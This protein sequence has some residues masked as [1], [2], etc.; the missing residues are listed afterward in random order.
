MREYRYTALTTSGHTVSG[1]RH[2][3]SAD[4]LAAELLGQRLILL[5]SRLTLGSFG[6]IFSASHR[7]ARG[8]LREFTRHMATCLRAGIP[9]LTALGDYQANT[10]GTFA[11]VIADIRGDVSSGTALDESLGRHPHI[12]SPLYLA[13]ITAGQRSGKL[14]Q[15]FDE[16][17]DYLD[18]NDDLR[19][20]TSQAMIYPTLLLLAITGLFLLMML[21]VIP[22]FEEVFAVADFAMPPLTLYMLALGHWMGHWWWLLLGG[23]GAA[24]AAI[25]FYTRTERG[26]L[27]RDRVLLGTPV[28]GP[29]MSKL[30]LSRFSKT[31]SLIFAS[32]VDLLQ[33]L[34]LLR[35]V[36][37]NRVMS[38][39]LR[40]VRTRVSSGE[41]LHEAFAKFTVFPPLVQRL[42]AVG[43]QTGS[44]DTSLRSAS[45]Y[46]DKELPRDLKRAFTVFEALVIVLLGV[47][48]CVA[49]LALLMPI[50]SLRPNLG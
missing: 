44:L 30:A 34:E 7:A 21:F 36:V 49:A 3:P 41:S 45:S 20:Q 32:G 22:R 28:L 16:L 31:F 12:F 39:A 42:I 29:F 23:V 43:E 27:L 48:V 40:E 46:Y 47:L 9:A 33:L 25:S 2:A 8:E 14:D 38:D 15:S 24:A 6:N 4:E 11:E 35:G 26:A 19:A 18:W 50:M 1:V 17:V 13:M 37:D 5:K 10:V